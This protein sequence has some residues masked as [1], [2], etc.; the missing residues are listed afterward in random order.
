MAK[1]YKIKITPRLKDIIE[2]IWQCEYIPIENE[3][4]EH[5]ERLEKKLARETGIGDIEI[6]I[7]DGCIVGIG[8]VSR[9]MPLITRDKLE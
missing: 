4:W 8:N 2:R 7:D 1:K 6:F 9:T 5:V 3:Y